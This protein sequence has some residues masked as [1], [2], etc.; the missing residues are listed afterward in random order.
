MRFELVTGCAAGEAEEAPLATGFNTCTGGV[1]VLIEVC[2]CEGEG[3][4]ICWEDTE[5]VDG[6][7]CGV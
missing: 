2:V 3:D 5:G 1:V 6:S 4:I 7:G